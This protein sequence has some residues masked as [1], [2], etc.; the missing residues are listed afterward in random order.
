MVCNK[1]RGQKCKGQEI[2]AENGI[3]VV[4]SRA[5]ASVMAEDF[6]LKQSIIDKRMH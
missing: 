1:L 2:V 4:T 5:K 3:R 6:V